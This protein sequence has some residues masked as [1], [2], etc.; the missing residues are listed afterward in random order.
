MADA[1]RDANRVTDLLGTSYVDG[2]TPVV[3]WAD[4]TTHELF[5]TASL[6]SI[7]KT[8]KTVTGT[9]SADTD[10]VN[11]V[12][13]KRIKVIAFS[14]ISGSTNANTVTFQSNAS[15]ALWTIPTQAITGTYFGA[16]LAVEAPSFIFATAAGE[17]LTLDVSSSNNITYSVSYFDDDTT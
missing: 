2:R 14:I 7:S 4:P 3:I 12:S 16:N 17:K 1:P 11:A 6:N 13:S 8:I 10:I 9:V 5:V 15:T